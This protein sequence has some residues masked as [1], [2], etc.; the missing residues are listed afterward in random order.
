MVMDMESREK[1]LIYLKGMSVY[2]GRARITDQTELYYDLQLFGDDL[3]QLAKWLEKKFGV[4]ANLDPQ[5][6]GPP[7]SLISTLFRRWRWRWDRA[8]R[9]YKS[10]RVADIFSIIDAGHW[11]DRAA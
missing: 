5:A 1:V 2:G 9:H 8:G 10:L 11:P 4:P 7:E 6:Y 3:C